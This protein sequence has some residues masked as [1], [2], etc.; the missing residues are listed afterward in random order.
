[1][2]HQDVPERFVLLPDIASLFGVRAATARCRPSGSTIGSA[3]FVAH[4]LKRL[5]GDRYSGFQITRMLGAFAG[6]ADIA[7]AP[8]SGLEEDGSS[9]CTRSVGVR[10]AVRG[11]SKSEQRDLKFILTDLRQAGL[12]TYVEDGHQATFHVVRHPD[13][14]QRFEQFYWDVM[15]GVIPAE[16]ASPGVCGGA[17]HT[18]KVPQF[19]RGP[20]R[21]HAR[22]VILALNSLMS[23]VY[24][25][26]AG[27]Y[28]G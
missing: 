9:H 28:H 5:Q 23:Q 16:S 25:F 21:G 1:V 6:C 18:R 17:R 3:L 7:T 4:Q 26:F 24:S 15:A 2:L 14:A 13:H 8:A 27:A 22:S 19:R 11:L 20:P 12:L 10:R